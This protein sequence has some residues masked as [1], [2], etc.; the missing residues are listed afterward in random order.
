MSKEKKPLQ[1]Q[2]IVTMIAFMLVGAVCGFIIVGF[3][4]EMLTDDTPLKTELLLFF[5]MLVGIYLSIFLSFI[6]HEAG[7]LVFGLMTGY[8]FCSYRIGSLLLIKQNGKLRIKK[9]SI[10]GTGGQCLMVPPDMVYGSFPVTAYNL[11]GVLMNLLIF[12]ICLTAYFVI[13]SKTLFTG[14][15]LVN[16]V[17]NLAIALTN[18][19]PMKGAVNNDGHNAFS[20]ESNKAAMRAFWL[21]LKINEAMSNGVN[22]KDMD[23]SWFVMPKDE[24][25]SN[26]I[27]GDIAVFCCN[28]YLAEHR[29]DEA[30][31][32]ITH[33]ISTQ[34][35]IVPINKHLLTAD[36]IYIM[37][38]SGEPKEQID[39]L[40]TKEQKKMMKLLSSMPSILRTEYAYALLAEKNDK[41]A[42]KIKKQLNNMAKSYPYA[43]E[44]ASE[45]ELID[46]ADKA[47]DKSLE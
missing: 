46:I 11:G 32:A 20:L 9:Y 16:A 28:R 38:I 24:E 15:L 26:S 5:G 17:V 42:A 40:L 25:L 3:M 34:N 6:I 43:G 41:K 31:E 23:E 35:S 22:I 1:W 27:V 33:L 37:L 19:I 21:E 18:G 12:V 8:K 39:L 47:A 13:D 44:I 29:F 2:A 14:L 10:A 30:K 36:K 45:Q 7:H 4:D